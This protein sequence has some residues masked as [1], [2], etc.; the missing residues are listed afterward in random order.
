MF[1][2][3]RAV[4]EGFPGSPLLARW[5]PQSTEQTESGPA[6]SNGQLLDLRAPGHRAFRGC[7]IPSYVVTGSEPIL[8][9][10]GRVCFGDRSGQRV[11]SILRT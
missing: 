6:E 3:F 4:D 8:G 7:R 10:A 2:S 5:D 11:K 1:D 9:D